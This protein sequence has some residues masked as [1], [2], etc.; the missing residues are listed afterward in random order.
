MTVRRERGLWPWGFWGV[1][2]RLVFSCLVGWEQ[3]WLSGDLV[4]LEGSGFAGSPGIASVACSEDVGRGEAAGEEEFPGKPRVW[5]C[6]V[7]WFLSLGA[8]GQAGH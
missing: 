2:V 4:T 8:Q 5:L 6:M 3:P 7:V 1:T